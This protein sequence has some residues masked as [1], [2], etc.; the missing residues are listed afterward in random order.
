[1]LYILIPIPIIILLIIAFINLLKIREKYLR[2]LNKFTDECKQFEAVVLEQILTD[3][4]GK[5][6]N[7]VIIQFRD[8][9][10]HKTVV[11]KY[12][13]AHKR[14]YKRG[15][16]VMFFY[17][18]SNDLSCIY[19]DNPFSRNAGIYLNC[20]FIS[21]ILMILLGIYEILMII[22]LLINL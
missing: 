16:K 5:K 17:N 22:Y 1:M 8:E 12:T 6:T 14:G 13:L 21:F 9:E 18:E 20:A 7:E 3:K 19:N 15:D 4:D 11:H 2:G 10:N